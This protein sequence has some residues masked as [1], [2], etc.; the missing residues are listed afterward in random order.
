MLAK[1]VVK[2]GLCLRR[3]YK[4]VAT[5]VSCSSKGVSETAF[6]SKMYLGQHAA[7]LSTVQQCRCLAGPRSRT[8]VP[9]RSDA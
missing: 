8:S 1:A 9:G 5:Q 3:T 4:L 6:D 2:V 7:M